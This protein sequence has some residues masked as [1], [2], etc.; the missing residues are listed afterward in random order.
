MNHYFLDKNTNDDSDMDDQ[1][2]K[3]PSA[4]LMEEHERLDELTPFQF[5]VEQAKSHCSKS[6]DCKNC[7]LNCKPE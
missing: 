1:S 5:V 7:P 4:K 2:I 6:D 3:F